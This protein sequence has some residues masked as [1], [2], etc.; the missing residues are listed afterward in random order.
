VSAPSPAPFEVIPYSIGDLERLLVEKSR[1]GAHVITGKGHRAYFDEYFQHIGA[2]TI[3]VENEYTDR[4]F[5]ED[6]AAYYVRCF[7]DYRRTCARLHFFSLPFTHEDF[8]SFLDGSGTSLTEESLR[9]GY[10]GFIVVKPLPE[11]V[12][13]RTC[14]RTYPTAI[15]ARHF[16]LI[17]RYEANLFGVQLSVETLAY[18]EQD[19]VAAACATSALWSAFQGTGR[20]F[21]HPIPSPVEITKAATAHSPIR[22]RTFPNS[23]GLTIEEM[24]RAIQYVGLEPL[25]VNVTNNAFLLKSTVYAYLKGSI[26]LILGHR[27]MDPTPP[28]DIGLHAVAV[29]GFNIGSSTPQPVG[30]GFQLRA[31]RIDKFYVHD[32]QVGPFARMSFAGAI[33]GIPDA[34]ISLMTSWGH[35][36]GNHFRA[37]PLSLLVPLYHKIRIPFSPVALT[38]IAFDDFMEK[39]RVATSALPERVEWEIYLT[40]VSDLK[41]S[42]ARDPNVG[43]SY[44]ADILTTILPRYVWRATALCA[45]IPVL[46]LLFDATDIEQGTFFLRAIEYDAG[47][48]SVLRV[49]ASQPGAIAAAHS[50]HDSQLVEWFQR[51]PMPPI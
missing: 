27:L 19:R 17:R 10:L 36:S 4:D 45:D 46:D 49:V 15:D 22:T 25:F 5:L 32:D 47:L 9:S 40:T 24:A 31:A 11:T 50:R 43:G 39:A 18:Q 12:I 2:V 44:R 30:A 34:G 7:A 26:P 3:V 16:P 23:H 6:F 14:L 37:V 42:I 13:G 21:Q 20:L 1:A 38:V 41:A 28:R 48:A 29:T 51:Q 8:A 33:S 35:S